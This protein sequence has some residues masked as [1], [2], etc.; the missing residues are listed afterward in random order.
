MS[1]KIDSLLKKADFFEK[2]A[3]Y[4]GKKAFGQIPPADQASPSF[5]ETGPGL[6]NFHPQNVIVPTSKYPE[7]EEHEAHSKEIYKTIPWGTWLKGLSE[8]QAALITLYPNTMAGSTADGI[9]GT[10]TQSA[11]NLWRADHHD[12]RAHADRSLWKDIILDANLEKASKAGLPKH[13]SKKKV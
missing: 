4:G 3:V 7:A 1:S 12:N 9:W 8:V 2:L 10:R 11:V 6:T 13:A 5:T